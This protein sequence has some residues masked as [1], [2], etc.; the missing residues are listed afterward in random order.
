[1]LLAETNASNCLIRCKEEVPSLVEL[2]GTLIAQIVN[3]LILVGILTKF[4]YKPLMQALEDRQKKIADS[5]DPAERERQEAQQLKLNYQQQ[6]SDARAEAQAIVE[7]GENFTTV[8]VGKLNEIKEYE[9]AMGNFSIPGKMFAGH[10]LQA[11]GAE[12]SF[13]SL[14]AG[15]DYGTRHTHKTHE[16]LYFIL[17]GEG[18]FDVDGKRF[19]VSEGSIV[20]IATKGKRAFKNT[21]STEMLVLWVHY[22]AN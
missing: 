7:K 3:F 14:A 15:Q 21:G 10:A 1:M 13:Q 19:P 4:A 6:L 8:N 5:I 18:I 11:T 12:L 22:K 17:K 16:E 20:R 9:L 2:N